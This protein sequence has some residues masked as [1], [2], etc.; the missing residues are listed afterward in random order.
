[1]R[2]SKLNT[3]SITTSNTHP[4][5]IAHFKPDLDCHYVSSISIIVVC[6]TII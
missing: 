5:E 2:V 6:F 1:M 4:V 3:Y